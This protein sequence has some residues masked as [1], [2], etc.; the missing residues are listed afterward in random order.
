MNDSDSHWTDRLTNRM[1]EVPCP[2]AAVLA[3]DFARRLERLVRVQQACVVLAH[4]LLHE[5]GYDEHMNVECNGTIWM[6]QIKEALA[7]YESLRA[8]LERG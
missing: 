8:E 1:C 5:E 3:I 2:D 7:A 6:R 4:E